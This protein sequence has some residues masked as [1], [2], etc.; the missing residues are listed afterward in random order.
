MKRI[1]FLTV[2]GSMLASC[3]ASGVVQIDSSQLKLPPASGSTELASLDLRT[4]PDGGF[5]VNPDA[6]KVLADGPVNAAPLL[7]LG[8]NARDALNATA[9]AGSPFAIVLRI[10]D[11]GKAGSDPSFGDLQIASDYAP[12][13]AGQTSLHHYYHPL[14][15]LTLLSDAELTDNCAV[16]L[17]PGSSAI[18][19]LVYPAIKNSSSVYWGWFGG[20]AVTLKRGGSTQLPPVLNAEYCSPAP[21]QSP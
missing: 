4:T 21:V 8:G 11:N 10:T 7:A 9:P 5:Y 20:P 12:A 1:I 13:Q 2:L 17:D 18:V 14:V 19:I 16:H 6:I 15:P 3:G